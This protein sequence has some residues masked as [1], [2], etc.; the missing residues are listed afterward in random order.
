MARGKRPAG[1]V[2]VCAAGALVLSG[3]LHGAAAQQ[4]AT[5]QQGGAQ[6]PAPS[7]VFQVGRTSL[8]WVDPSRTDPF[9][10]RLATRREVMVYVW[11]PT[12][13]GVTGR[14]APYVPHVD[15]I[16]HAL[17]DSLMRD[18]FGAALPR[19]LAGDV[20]SYALDWPPLARARPRYPVLVFSP[21]FGETSLT[22]A[23]QLTDLA[24]HGFVVF[25]IEHPS[26]A[27]A[28]WLPD[29]RVVPFAASS[30]DSARQRPT[31]AVAYQLAQ[32]P[33]RADDMRFVLDRVTGLD[34]RPA[35]RNPFAHRLD[36]GRVGAFGHSLGGV[37]AADACRVDAR[38]R[39]CANEDADDEGRPFAGGPAAHL[40]KQ[41]F[42]FFA[43]G[44][45]IYVSAR[46]PPPTAQALDRMKLTRA[47]YDSITALYQHNQDEA[48]ARMPGGAER[49][50]AEAATFTH[51][52]FIDLKLL[53]AADTSAREEQRHDLDLVRA[54][55]RAFFDRTLAD[56]ADS[57]GPPPPTDSI[58]T[59]EHFGGTAPH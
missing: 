39:A 7:G 23:A 49:V 50:M 10:R 1:A 48:L 21:G 9:A 34:A 41:P 56:T 3:G 30:W 54:Y 2:W 8:H 59:V 33:V 36:L 11:Y 25:A 37:A 16:A 51:R 44:H 52:T 28:V 38:I 13:R 55:L 29:G 27:F 47:Q 19:V 31:G 6:L 14:R 57:G 35:P 5:A 32:V 46:T 26:D 18:E 43:S 53:Q 42:L 45:S 15:A 4:G 40:I 20:D 24:S 58:I 17:G 12:D 22:Y